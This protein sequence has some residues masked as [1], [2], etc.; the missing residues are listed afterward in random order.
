MILINLD[1]S[2]LIQFITSYI[3]T[4]ANS[5][6][7][8]PKCSSS[9]VKNLACFKNM[10][11]KANKVHLGHGLDIFF[12]YNPL[13]P[14]IPSRSVQRRWY[15]LKKVWPDFV[16]SLWK[17]ATIEKVQRWSGKDLQS[18]YNFIELRRLLKIPTPCQTKIHLYILYTMVFI[19]IMHDIHWS[20]S[21]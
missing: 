18:V 10:Q 20:K 12:A 16:P 19:A 21:W 11:N 8:V 17:I 4:L 7:L 13:I 9:F 6:L 1:W 15:S 2:W 14:V 3:M 5:S